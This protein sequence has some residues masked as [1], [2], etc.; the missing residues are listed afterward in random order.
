MD[1]S[2][3]GPGSRAVRNLTD[4]SDRQPRVANGRLADVVT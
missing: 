2:S 1:L 3:P 4:A